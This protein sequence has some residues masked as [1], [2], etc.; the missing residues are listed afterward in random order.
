MT[1]HPA[2]A[3]S[4]APPASAPAPA[5]TLPP[6]LAFLSATHAESAGASL[7]VAGL[8]VVERALKQLA[9]LPELRVVVLSDG[10]IPLPR[11]LPKN[12]Q[13][14]PVTTAKIAAEVAAEVAAAMPP[15]E[16]PLLIAAD[17][18]RLPR[19]PLTGGVR[20]VDESTRRQAED[21]IFADLLRGDLGLV[22]RYI[23]KKISF[24]ITRYLLCKLP[25]TPN[26]VTLGAAVIGFAGCLL[27]AQGTY[28]ATVA[29]FLLAQVQ[30]VLDGCDGELARVRFQQS[31]IGEWLDTL[32]DDFLNFCLVGSM[33]IGLVQAGYGWTAAVASAAGCVM[34]LVYNAV[35]YRELVRQGLGGELL[36]IHW[37]LTRGI[38]LK[39]LMSEGNAGSGSA[40]TRLLLSLGRRDV[41]IFSWLLL[42]I[43]K[44]VPGALFWALVIALSCFV[45]AVGQLVIRGPS[46]P[47]A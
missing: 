6:R 3:A 10:T 19:D 25:V 41:F 44:L 27:I 21:G 36:K 2:P 12:A 33:G 13:L 9:R 45:T 8:S 35:S 46:R 42:A 32:V 18:V 30:S 20:V 29:G 17:V 40:T 22:A 43:V 7:K 4:P 11:V 14:R 26:Q 34:L 47:A 28:V 31:A 24:R 23:N 39:S 1:D 16:S 38:E 5:P 15:S 37:K